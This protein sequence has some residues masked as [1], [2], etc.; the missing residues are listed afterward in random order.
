MT[1][2]ESLAVEKER[3]M[4][5]PEPEPLEDP[6]SLVPRIAT[7][8]HSLWLTWTYPFVSVGS[9][10]SIHHSCELKRSVS[11]HIKIGNSVLLTRDVWLNVPFVPNRA[12]PV[13]ILDDNVQIGRRCQ[14]SGKNRIHFERNAILASDV[15][16]MDH[17]HAYEDVNVPILKQ[18]T[19]PGGTIRIEEDC[20]IGLGAVIISSQ[21][22][23]VI[24]K[25]SVVAANSMVTHSIPPYSV[26]AGNP[27][28]VVRYYDPITETWKM[29]SRNLVGQ[30]KGEMAVAKP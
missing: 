18:E 19:T 12:E 24:G 17:N 5:R 15:L 13:I 11:N 16:V 3:P 8:L 2:T 29:G 4:A 21:G 28:R 6:L 23:L 14:I 26:V 25:H 10:F 30:T 27:A 9:K 1:Q 20:W 7:K 22:E